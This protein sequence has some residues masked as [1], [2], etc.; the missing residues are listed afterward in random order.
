MCD[1]RDGF[2]LGDIFRGCVVSHA[3]GVSGDEATLEFPRPSPTRSSSRLAVTGYDSREPFMMFSW[4]KI[5]SVCKL[6][7]V[8]AQ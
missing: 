4:P 7:G 8:E 1:Q 2:L 5:G 6:G 3:A